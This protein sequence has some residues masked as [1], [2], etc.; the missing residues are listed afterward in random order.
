MKWSADISEGVNVICCDDLTA[1]KTNG[2]YVHWFSYVLVCLACI[3]FSV[4]TIT[5]R[6]LD[7]VRVLKLCIEIVTRSGLIPKAIVTHPLWENM[8]QFRLIGFNVQRVIEPATD[9]LADGY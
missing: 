2:R 6:V 3:A 7:T 1:L 4:R 9:G 5:M 8:L